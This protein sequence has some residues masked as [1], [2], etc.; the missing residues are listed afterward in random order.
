MKNMDEVCILCGVIHA[1]AGKPMHIEVSTRTSTQPK[2]FSHDAIGLMA[3]IAKNDKQ[4]LEKEKLKR[5]K[6]GPPPVPND[7]F[8]DDDDVSFV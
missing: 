5:S 6:D 8:N 2:S 1:E 7:P 4:Y 3:R